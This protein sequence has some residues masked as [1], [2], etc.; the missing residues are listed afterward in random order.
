M[1][2]SILEKVR[3]LR[4]QGHSPKQIARA[5]GMAPA[6]VAPYVR[7]V[8]EQ[9]G[10]Q[11]AEPEL[12]GCWINAG[13]GEG[14]GVPDTSGWA[15]DVPDGQETAGTVSVVVARK[16][17]WD[18]LSVCAYLVDVYCLGVKHAL[19]PD[20]MSE[21]ELHRFLP[22]WFRIY[23]Y[24]SRE[25]PLDLVRHLVFGAVDY[26]RDLGFEPAA[27]FAGAAGHLGTWEEKAAI[28]FGKDGRPFYLAGPNDDA[29]HVVKTLE[30]RVG[31]PPNFD[32]FAPMPESPI[33]LGGHRLTP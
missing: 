1:D 18:K 23:P 27:D 10:G 16:H 25:A 30:R 5:L 28:T 6:A 32:F 33:S 19:G 12:A 4:G 13:W 14:L 8:A 26:A 3:E 21:V 24:G 11:A 22:K 29:R 17:G 9:T 2:S 15:D 7:A 31:P 20:V